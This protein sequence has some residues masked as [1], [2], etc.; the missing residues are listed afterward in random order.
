[1]VLILKENDFVSPEDRERSLQGMR[2][3]IKTGVVSIPRHT[4][5]LAIIGGEYEKVTIVTKEEAT[6]NETMGRRLL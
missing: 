4:E 5:L 3:Q 2:D 6:G 1:M